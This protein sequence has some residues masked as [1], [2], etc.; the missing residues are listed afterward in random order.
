MNERDWSETRFTVVRFR[1]CLSVF[2][3][4]ENSF[5]NTKILRLF[6]L[7]YQVF[8]EGLLLLAVVNRD[9][10][11]ARAHLLIYPQ[12]V[13]LETSLLASWGIG[14][15]WLGKQGRTS[16]SPKETLQ[17]VTSQVLQFAGT[18][19]DWRI[20]VGQL[21]Q[22]LSIPTRNTWV[23]VLARWTVLH[24]INHR[25]CPISLDT[26]TTIN[27]LVGVSLDI[28]GVESSRRSISMIIIQCD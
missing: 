12:N 17:A 9:W 23:S 27:K 11:T 1:R 16:Q 14:G 19:G 7:S 20:G 21:G 3:F 13:V 28:I 26:V 24:D 8:G 10:T 2:C 5:V 18:L 4:A 25:I 22:N 6:L 15:L